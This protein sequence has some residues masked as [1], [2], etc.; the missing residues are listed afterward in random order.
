ME[1]NNLWLRH[2]L[3]LVLQVV[4]ALYVFWKSIGR[5]SV[6]LLIS[7]IFVFV[8]GIIKY[9]ERT[10]SLK[11]GSFKNLESSTG[12]HCKHQ[13]PELVDGDVCY[14]NTVCTGLRSMLDVLNFFSGRT[15]FIGSTVR[16]GREGLGTWQPDQ[17]LKVLG[18]ELGMMYDDLYTKAIMLR[19]RSGIILRSCS[20]IAALVAFMLFFTCNKRQYSKTDL[21]ITYSLFVGGFILEICAVFRVI[22]SPWTWAWLKTRKYNRLARFS[23]SLFSSGPIGWPEK[24]PL[25]SNAMGQYNLSTWFEGSGQA[26]SCSQQ[27]MNTV[28]KFATLVGVNKDK[29]FWLSKLLDVEYVNAGE[30]MNCLVRAASYF[31]RE[32]YEFQKTREWPNLDPLLR[33]AQV[34]YIADFGFA[35]VFMHMVTELHLSKYPCSSDMEEDVAAEIDA[36][37]EVCQKLSQYMMHLLL[38]L[39]SLL[40]LNASAVATLDKWQA[41]M[42]ENDIM[43]ELK[44]LDPQ[45]GKEVLEEIKEIWVRLIIYAAAKSKPEMHAAQ[46]ARGGEPLT[47][48]WLQLAH[49]NCGD[50]GFSRIELTRDRSKH[51]IFYVLQLQES[52]MEGMG[53]PG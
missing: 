13:F 33:Y 34:F 37:V 23:W 22:M 46:L 20:Q 16:F 9:G 51:S 38:S 40:P 2:L 28:R 3:N 44:E 25:W 48:V 47:F 6:G 41:D 5:H 10:W 8:A 43:S 27:V 35:I 4:L 17:V 30:V 49:Y 12:D 42:S 15:L 32:P 29:I 52:V 36:L 45:P 39:P 7:G 14:S 1:D 50:F 11:Y 21:A 19:T 53:F 24:R 31:V 26:K 18:I